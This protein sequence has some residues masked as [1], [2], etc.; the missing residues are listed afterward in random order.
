MQALCYSAVEVRLLTYTPAH[1][2]ISFEI[3]DTGICIT[4]EALPRLFFPF[5]QADGSTTRK[6]GGT[7]LGLA[8]SKRLVEMMGG[9]INVESEPGC[10]R[11]FAFTARFDKAGSALQRLHPEH[12]GADALPNAAA[13]LFRD[14]GARG[15]G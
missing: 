6:H 15:R 5:E 11:T 2:V 14:P 9:K 10:G 3:S 4:K 8:I 13:R 12:D 7:G 1:F